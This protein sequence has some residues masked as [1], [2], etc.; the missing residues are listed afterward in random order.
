MQTRAF[1]IDK[2]LCNLVGK[3]HNAHDLVDVLDHALDHDRGCGVAYLLEQRG[4]R[5]PAAVLILGGRGLLLR[6]NQVAG[7]IQQFLEERD[8]VLPLL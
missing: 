4:E 3:A 1:L 5:G 2:S 7:Q 6:G 8:A